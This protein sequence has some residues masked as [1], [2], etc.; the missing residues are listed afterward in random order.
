MLDE[1]LYTILVSI[2]MISIFIYHNS[3]LHIKYCYQLNNLYLLVIKISYY[4]LTNDQNLVNKIFAKC[5]IY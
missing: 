1:S 5:Q 2:C 3:T 4:L